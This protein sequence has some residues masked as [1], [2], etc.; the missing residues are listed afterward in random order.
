MQ[1]DPLKVE[2]RWLPR[3]AIFSEMSWQFAKLPNI[4]RG[5]PKAPIHF[6]ARRDSRLVDLIPSSLHNM[7]RDERKTR[8][9][10]NNVASLVDVD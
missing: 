3:L 10:K 2:T 6:R 7:T 5:L 1:H 4:R 8:E 9:E